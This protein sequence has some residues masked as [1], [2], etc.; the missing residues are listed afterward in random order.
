MGEE[1]EMEEEDIYGWYLGRE[2][3]GGKHSGK[4]PAW[5]K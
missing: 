3:V 4:G 5:V 1:G 2:G